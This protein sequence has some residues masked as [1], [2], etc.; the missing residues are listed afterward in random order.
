M[1]TLYPNLILDALRNVRYPASGKDIVSAGMVA[2]DIRIDGNKVS[3][4]LVFDRPTDPFIKSLVR[5][6]ETAIETYISPEVQIKGNIAVQTRQAMPQPAEKPLKQV[7]NIIGVSSGKG[8]VGKST[9][10][11]NLAV[12]LAREGY[13]VGLL[14][15][16]IFGPSMPKMFG[17]EDE[18]LYMHKVDGRDLI[19][20]IER[21]GV[22]LLSIGFL[23]D[24]NA[25]VL[26]RGSMASN[27]LKQL[28]N[29]ADW[30][31]LDYFLIDMPPGTS[32]I[33][34]TLVQTLAITGVVIV[35][36][37]QDVA[38]ADARKGIAMFLGDKI[39]VPILGLVEN[40]AWFTP[41]KHPDERYYIFGR[42]GGVRLAKELGVKLLAQLPLVGSV[43]ESGDGGEPIAARDTMM[44]RDFIHL[45]HE[46]VD[47]CDQRNATLPPTHKVELK[48]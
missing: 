47:A 25:P 41:E 4:S 11:A 8:G 5:A 2:D 16:D 15:A 42:E 31:E 30:G 40:M 44:G 19:I 29:D 7:K 48:K 38:L 13:K 18:S 22:K 20:P 36:T 46:V 10:A 3:F 39:N 14:D 6:A 33:H 35:T 9:V 45:A 24:K 28:I 27:A 37:P 23:V 12:A 26:W 34:L 21:Y 43:C 17:V 1:E 32:D